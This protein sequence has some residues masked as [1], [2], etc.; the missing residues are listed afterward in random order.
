MNTH[1]VGLN[2]TENQQDRED[3][4]KESSSEK[5]QWHLSLSRNVNKAWTVALSTG[6]RYS[7]GTARYLSCML[8]GQISAT[9][10]DVSTIAHAFALIKVLASECSPPQ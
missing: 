1:V 4:G 3:G 6:S 10:K 9:N 8:I 2:V 7:T 5:R